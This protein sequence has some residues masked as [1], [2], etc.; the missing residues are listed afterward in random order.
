M[1]DMLERFYKENYSVVYGYLLSLC[2]DPVLA[3]E[4][5]AE[6]FSKAL[7]QLHRYDPKYKPSTWLCTI[8]RNLL[9]NEYRRRKKLTALEDADWVS[10]PSAEAAYIQKE[11]VR[12]IRSYL[13][14]LPSEQQQLF[15]MR[16]QGMS[17]RDIGL[18]LNK[19]EN[20]A[21]V[22]YYRIKHKIRTEMEEE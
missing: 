11:L 22:T 14:V 17:F 10:V 7:H 4:L 8:G 5:T 12:H 18:A 15:R 13:K 19:N 20:W 16:L 1:K 21:R 3:E 9:Y 2:G 6:T